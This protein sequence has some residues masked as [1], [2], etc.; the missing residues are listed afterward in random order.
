MRG[1]VGA[2]GLLVKEATEIA[3]LRLPASMLTRYAPQLGM[4][5]SDLVLCQIW[6]E[7]VILTGIFIG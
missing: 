2:P 7:K 6:T 3:A 4:F 1:P 5:S